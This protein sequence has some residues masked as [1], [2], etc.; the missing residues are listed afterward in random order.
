M[1]HKVISNTMSEEQVKEWFKEND[2]FQCKNLAEQFLPCNGQLLNQLYEI[3]MD[4]PEFYYQTLKN[5][6]GLNL[7]SICLFTDKLKEL[8]LSEKRFEVVC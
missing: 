4:G 8:I 6:Y 7:K 2:F 5:D 3:K 1:V